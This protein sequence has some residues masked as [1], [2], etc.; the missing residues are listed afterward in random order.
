MSNKSENPPAEEDFQ[1][2]MEGDKYLD[3]NYID[4]VSNPLPS[5]KQSKVSRL[6]EMSLH[7]NSP[8]AAGNYWLT[9]PWCGEPKLNFHVKKWVFHCYS[10]DRGRGMNLSDLMRYLR[11]E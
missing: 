9:C 11:I 2:N 6:I 5:V 4:I 7:D 3:S 10:C 8:D 1:K